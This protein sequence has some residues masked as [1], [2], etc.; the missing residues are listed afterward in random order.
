MEDHIVLIKYLISRT[1]KRVTELVFE[2]EFFSRVIRKI[3]FQFHF[4]T[5]FSNFKTKFLSKY[6]LILLHLFFRCR[7]SQLT[8]H[9]FWNY[10]VWAQRESLFYLLKCFFMSWLVANQFLGI[11]SLFAIIP[12]ILSA[13]LVRKLI[14]HICL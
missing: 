1:L 11:S 9:N 8:L 2:E 12:I 13:I 5:F 4:R 10:F 14:R 7:W 3:R 6:F